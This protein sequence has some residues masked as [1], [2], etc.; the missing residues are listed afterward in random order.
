MGEQDFYWLPPGLLCFNWD[1][2]AFYWVL[3]GLT[4]FRGILL[5]V[6]LD[7]SWLCT[8]LRGLPSVPL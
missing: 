3:R 7:Y 1:L 5:F 2:R 6:V 4:W 8:L